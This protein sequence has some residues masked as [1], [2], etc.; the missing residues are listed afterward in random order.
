[1]EAEDSAHLGPSFTLVRRDFTHRRARRDFTHTVTH[2]RDLTHTG[3][4]RE[5]GA[6]CWKISESS[7]LTW[8][9]KSP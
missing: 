2:R 7:W 4:H 5:T 9:L 8:P 6:I 3:P 1:M